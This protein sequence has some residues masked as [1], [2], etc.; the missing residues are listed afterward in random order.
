VKWNVPASEVV[1]PRRRPMRATVVYALGLFALW[2]FTIGRTPAFLPMMP[3]PSATV[4]A[5]VITIA[6]ALVGGVAARWLAD[7][8]A[9][10]DRVQ[11]G[12]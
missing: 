6:M 5:L 10:A 12:G 3:G 1:L 11:A 8:L 9:T 7:T 4:V 2:A